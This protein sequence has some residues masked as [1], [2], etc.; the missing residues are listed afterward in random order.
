MKVNKH[1]LMLPK[2]LGLFKPLRPLKPHKP[3]KRQH[4]QMMVISINALTQSRG[5]SI[6][7]KKLL[8]ADK[9]EFALTGDI[10]L[11]KLSL[12]QR[13]IAFVKSISPANSE[14]LRMSWVYFCTV[15]LLCSFCRVNTNI[16]TNSRSAAE[17]VCTLIEN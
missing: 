13:S 1:I 6:N 3:P 2:P 5:K 7:F 10:S 8:T 17:T 11:R 12:K 9:M 14:N 4:S 15:S 16:N